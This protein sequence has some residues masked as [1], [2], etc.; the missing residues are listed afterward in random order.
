MLTRASAITKRGIDVGSEIKP[1]TDVL[2]I[3]F[4]AVEEGA[5][6]RLRITEIPWY[7]PKVG[8]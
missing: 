4:D 2:A 7:Y 8:F 1:D 6:K 3:W 5:S